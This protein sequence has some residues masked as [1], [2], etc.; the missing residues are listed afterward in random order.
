LSVTGIRGLG[1]I[2]PIGGL[3]LLGAW[4]ALAFQK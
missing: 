1:A 4:L 2:T 3:C